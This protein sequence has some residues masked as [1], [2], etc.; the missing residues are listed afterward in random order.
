M[1]ERHL[2]AMTKEEYA[3]LVE[4]SRPV[5][6]MVFGGMEPESPRER[7]MRVWRDLA[8]K[9]HFEVMTVQAGADPLHFT[10]EPSDD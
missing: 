7:A 9:Y 10:A 4:A 3:R 5:P 1:S 8:A 6:Y 2:Y